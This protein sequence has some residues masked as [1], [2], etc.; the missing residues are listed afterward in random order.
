MKLNRPYIIV[1]FIII[2]IYLLLVLFS[3]VVFPINIILG[4]ICILLLPGYNFLSLIKPNSSLLQKLG[5]STIISLGIENTLMFII[6]VY[7]YD[8]VNIT[9]LY[10]FFF[11][12]EMLI[13]IIQIISI[14]LI[15]INLFKNKN[16]SRKYKTYINFQSIK[17]SFNYKSLWII[18]GFVI[19][20]ILL[21]ISTYLNKISNNEF[22]IV[23]VDYREN[24]TFFARVPF[25]FYIFLGSSIV[26]LTFI[27]FFIKNK[28]I[29]LFCISVFIYC[30]WILPYLQIGNYFGQD[31]YQL[32]FIYINYKYY[33]IHTLRNYCFTLK[34]YS[35]LRYSTSLFTSIL[36]TNSTGVEIEFALMFLYPLI[37]IFIPFFFYSIF[38][39]FSDIK[40][41]SDLNLR[42]LVVFAIIS[43]LIIKFP[44]SAT[45][46]VIGL[47]IFFMLVLEFYNWIHENKLKLKYMLYIFFLYFVLNLTHFEECI[48][49]ILVVFFYNIYYLFFKIKEYNKHN[50]IEKISKKSFIRTGS[51]LFILLMIFFLVQEF[52]GYISHYFLTFENF[53]YLDN[54]YLFYIQTKVNIISILGGNYFISFFLFFLII[55]GVIMYGLFI[56]LL[57]YR[58]FNVIDNI[59]EKAV[60]FLTKLYP[61]I[62]EIIS[63]KIFQSL[64]PIIVFDV[65]LVVNLLFF[66]FLNEEGL[67]IILEIILSFSLIIFNV[68]LF[69]RG[70]VYYKIQNHKENYFLIGIIATSLLMIFFVIM[71]EIGFAF[72]I[73]SS[74][75]I[76]CFIFFNLIIIQNN[77]FNALTKKKK[78]FMVIMI[79][80]LL[81]FGVSYS[82]RKLSYA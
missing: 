64:I 3:I 10:G 5:M 39:K 79:I 9:P 67:F 81:I 59:Y 14:C 82:L 53:P 47:I 32:E 25:Y 18:V 80:L 46:I 54:I 50:K 41:E 70:V 28:Y 12:P 42:L 66:Q 20:L 13:V 38:Q 21:C 17:E 4:F 78:K 74:K 16:R 48:Y 29:M 22:S 52:F 8:Y 11:W 51:L 49:F 71:G 40:D 24:F 15:L 73:L 7:G 55:F 63:T 68:Y 1:E 65:F 6:Y 33:G 45:T 2:F 57:F 27:I 58:N 76:S 62:K 56:Y 31:S 34:Q 75:Y 26:F 60:D 23:R 61:T 43:P 77:Y 72:S 36:L 30:L 19:S 69:I 37:F 44:H 35:S